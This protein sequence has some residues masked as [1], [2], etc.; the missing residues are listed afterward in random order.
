LEASPLNAAPASTET[1][2]I[3]LFHLP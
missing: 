2:L 1:H 3:R